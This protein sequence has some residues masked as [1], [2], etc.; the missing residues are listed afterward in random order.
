MKKLLV[1]LCAATLLFG[2]VSVASASLLENGDFET[3]DFTGWTTSGDVSLDTW[4]A[5]YY[6]YLGFW[7][8]PA[9]GTH[10]LCQ[11]FYLEPLTKYVDV[12][13]TYMLRDPEQPPDVFRAALAYETST[14]TEMVEL[15]LENATTAWLSYTGSVE[16]MGLLDPSDPNATICFSL[17]ENYV[18]QTG[19]DNNAF[20]YL[21]DV[22]VEGRHSAVPEPASMMLLGTGLVGLAGLGRKK[23]LKRA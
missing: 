20:A 1:V 7:S 17:D 11:D 15:V 12:S 6:A 4:G 8:Q 3:G 10:T 13:F 14:G 22:V 23:L 16:L 9:G 18:C 19:W 5:G 2:A 21:D